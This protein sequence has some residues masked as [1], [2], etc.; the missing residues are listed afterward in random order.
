MDENDIVFEKTNIL[1]LKSL[2]ILESTTEI[3]DKIKNIDDFIG[4]LE[5]VESTFNLD[6]DFFFLKNY[7]IKTQSVLS[8]SSNKLKIKGEVRQRQNNN[9]INLNSLYTEKDKK[10]ITELFLG[11]EYSMRE[12]I[13]YTDS[14]LFQ[15][16]ANDYTIIKEMQ[17]ELH[18]SQNLTHLEPR[19]FMAS[20]SY[21]TYMIP[22]LYIMYPTITKMTR[23]YLEL[24]P[25]KNPNL[26][27]YVKKVQ[28]KLATFK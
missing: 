21:F 20:A 12:F 5:I 14:L 22:E 4:F 1:L 9:I 11:G 25:K 16:M 23:D 26:K 17:L 28:K 15:S 18:D 10:D 3:V 8:L 24:I 7:I 13:P 19:Q 6:K 2:L 27:K